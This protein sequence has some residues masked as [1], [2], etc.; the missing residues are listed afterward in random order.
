[1]EVP[2]PLLAIRSMIY[3]GDQDTGESEVDQAKIVAT[4]NSAVAIAFAVGKRKG[5]EMA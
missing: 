1:M 2:L 4:A 3:P 5:F